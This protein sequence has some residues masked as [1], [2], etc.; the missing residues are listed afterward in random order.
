ML[1]DAIALLCAL[2]IGFAAHR[3]SLCNVRA[4]E[5]IIKTGNARMLSSLLQSVLWMATLTGM[6]VLVLGL[7]PKPVLAPFPIGWALAGGLLFGLGAGVNGGCSLS[8]LHRLADGDLGMLVTLAGFLVGIC[9]WLPV[10]ESGT[11]VSLI[12]VQSPWLRWPQ[13]APWLLM[14]LVV[15]VVLRS[16]A[17]WQLARSQTVSSLRERLMAHSY[18]ASVSAAIMGIAGG[19]LY[20]TAGAWSY[21]NFLRAEV[22]HRLVN[23]MAPMA[24]HALL[25]VALLAGMVGSAVQRRSFAWRRPD[26]LIGWM[27]RAGGGIFMGAGASMIPGGNDT[28]LLG[29]LP[30]LSVAAVGAYAFL[31]AGIATSLRILRD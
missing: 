27:R 25:V 18:H 7:A 20:A 4:V 31:L 10:S 12:V 24:W 11:P 30:N 14:A 15:W 22:A 3:A 2:L 13:P 17:L 1:L 6:L 16:R 29:G 21:T 19:M 8:T 9:V 5:E 28:L 26:R 23:M